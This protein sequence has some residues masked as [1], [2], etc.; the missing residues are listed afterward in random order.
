MGIRWPALVPCDQME[1]GGK[2][3]H[4]A[5]KGGPWLMQTSELRPTGEWKRRQ[6]QSK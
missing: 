2:E 1:E 6:F 5:A 4:K 3:E